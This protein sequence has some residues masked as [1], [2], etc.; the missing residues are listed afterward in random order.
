M[1]LVLVGALTF[2]ST[3]GAA[4]IPPTAKCVKTAKELI[5]DYTKSVPDNASEATR[6]KADRKLAKGLAEADCISDAE[7]LL[8]KVELKPFTA[9]CKEGAKAADNY[10]M[11][12]ERRFA[13]LGRQW[14]RQTRPFN[15][16]IQRLNTRIARLRIKGASKGRLKPI[17]RKRAAL[18]RQR[19]RLSKRNEREM[20]RF[21]RSQSYQSLLIAS[22]LQA[23]RCVDLE[24]IFDDN[25]V[26]P[27]ARVVNKHAGLIFFSVLALVIDELNENDA[28]AS[29]AATSHS[30]TRLPFINLP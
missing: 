3:A 17:L 27:A 21:L 29:A 4:E 24:T 6:K 22:E 26:G 10:W 16:R 18:K 1:L 30:D 19:A 14:N 8:K 20:L 7:P 12:G 13:Q 2:A 11:P 28:S 9:E 15:R 23:R 5:Q 25:P